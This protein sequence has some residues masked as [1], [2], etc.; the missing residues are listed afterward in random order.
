MQRKMLFTP[1]A[2]LFT[3]PMASLRQYPEKFPQAHSILAAA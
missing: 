3:V 1:P 2:L